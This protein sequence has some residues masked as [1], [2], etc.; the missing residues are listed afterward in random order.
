MA[1]S[2]NPGDVFIPS[3]DGMSDI[4]HNPG[5]AY[6]MYLDGRETNDE[7]VLPYILF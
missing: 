5:H 3:D 7:Q 4:L 2:V 6:A 1:T